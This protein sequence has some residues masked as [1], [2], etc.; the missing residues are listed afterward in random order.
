MMDLKNNTQNDKCA[1]KLHYCTINAKKLSCGH[2]ICKRCEPPSWS[3]N[4]YRF[5][6]KIC[7]EINKYDLRIIFE[8]DKLKETSPDDLYQSIFL[9]NNDFQQ[10]F[11]RFSGYYTSNIPPI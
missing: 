11:K 7:H 8:I 9:T 10:L 6:C 2:Y 1:L 4:H 3:T 5:M